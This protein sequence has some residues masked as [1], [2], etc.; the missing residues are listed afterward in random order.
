MHPD[1]VAGLLADKA[2]KCYFHLGDHK[3]S[4]Q[5]LWDVVDSSAVPITHLVP[6]HME[7]TPKLLDE[8]VKWMRAGGHVDFSGWPDRQRAATLRYIKEGVPILDRLSISSDSYGSAPHFVNQ[9][10]V[11]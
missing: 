5:P 3:L 6:T 8:A 1:R 10:L 2:G 11:G 4:L 9:V 7:R